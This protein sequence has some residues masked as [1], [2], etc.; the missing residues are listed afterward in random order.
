MCSLNGFHY[1]ANEL[2]GTFGYDTSKKQVGVSAQECLKVMPEVVASAP[3]DA[4][5]YTVHYEK[6]V[7]LLIEAIKE[8]SE[9]K[10]ICGSK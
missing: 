2:A 10:C 1:Q 6:L 9:R 8:L 4:E 7:P 5:Y 3:I